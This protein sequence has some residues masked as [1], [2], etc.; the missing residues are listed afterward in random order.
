VTI[1]YSKPFLSVEDQ[2]V[3][4][5]SRG[6][7]IDDEVI[8]AHALDTIGY[9]NLSGYWYPMRRMAGQPHP[10]ERLDDF[11]EGVGFDDVLALYQFDKQLRLLVLEKIEQ[12]EQSI[13]VAVAQILGTVSTT[14]HAKSGFFR[15][16]FITRR[17][18]QSES[19]HEKWLTQ[20]IKTL[21][22][23]RS[24][25]NFI[26]HYLDHYDPPPPIW[27][28]IETWDF[29][30]TSRLVRGLKRPYSDNIAE[31]FGVSKSSVFESWL[32]AIGSVRNICAHHERL[33]NRDMTRQPKQLNDPFFSSAALT[34]K[35]W[36]RF[37]G[38]AL[39]MAYMDAVIDGTKLWGLRFSEHVA[40]LPEVPGVTHRAMGAPTTWSEHPAWIP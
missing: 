5:D 8:A 30:E 22:E 24:Q 4:L 29:G 34:N 28:A 40:S 33:W 38:I 19:R 32:A 7:R 11:E 3:L 10:R 27:I 16:D 13:K 37:Y 6:M 9:Y 18:G 23:R 17:P 21:E 36:H 15:D 12:I 35:T 2:L 25:W 26:D 39:V 14:A 31:R 20:H 1:R